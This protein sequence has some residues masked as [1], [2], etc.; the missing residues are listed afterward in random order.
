MGFLTERGSQPEVSEEYLSLVYGFLFPGSRWSEV[1][2][3]GPRGLFMSVH[4]EPNSVRIGSMYGRHIGGPFGYN[5][6]PFLVRDEI[7][8]PPDQKEMRLLLTDITLPQTKTGP[9]DI[10]VQILVEPYMNYGDRYGGIAQATLGV[11]S[12]PGWAV[13][14]A[15]PPN[16]YVPYVVNVMGIVND[17]QP[18]ALMYYRFGMD[19]NRPVNTPASGNP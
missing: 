10:A 12:R 16:D 1:P 14:A 11:L 8:A 15:P 2:S 9:P 4:P 18:A 19:V 17:G 7:P 5:P 13:I 6:M 3:V